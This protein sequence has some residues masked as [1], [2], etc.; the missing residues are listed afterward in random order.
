M[1]LRPARANQNTTVTSDTL[2][3]RRRA[4]RTLR[5]VEEADM[6]E[7]QVPEGELRG[8]EEQI[9]T[10]GEHEREHG[11]PPGTFRNP[12]GRDTRSDKFISTVQKEEERR[13][14]RRKRHIRHE[15]PK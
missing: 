3:C 1:K 6:A 5:L 2:V 12:G 10:V 8:D 7:E 4:N 14:R 15:P 13:L 11:F 9:K